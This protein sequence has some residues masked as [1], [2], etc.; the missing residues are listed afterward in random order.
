MVSLVLK[1]ACLTCVYKR[2]YMKVPAA[3]PPARQYDRDPPP[4]FREQRRDATAPDDFQT[5][6]DFLK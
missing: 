5:E 6:N 2:L 3:L 4:P 1:G